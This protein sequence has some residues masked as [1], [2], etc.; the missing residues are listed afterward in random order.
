MRVR[1]PY[2]LAGTGNPI[3]S[4]FGDILVTRLGILSDALHITTE[5]EAVALERADEHAVLGGSQTRHRVLPHSDV[6]DEL[7]GGNVVD[8]DGAILDSCARPHPD[9]IV[10][11][12]HAL[13]LVLLDEVLADLH[14]G[15]GVVD[16]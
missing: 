8:V 1:H 10:A 16:V 5:A 3:H 11:E 15:A 2:E 7:S 13:H 6:V 4:V 12:G 14:H 9:V